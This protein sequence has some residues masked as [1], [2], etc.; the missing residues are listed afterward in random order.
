[1][2]I[3][4]L[5][6]EIFIIVFTVSIVLL[7]IYFLRKPEESNIGKCK[8]TECGCEFEYNKKDTVKYKYEGK[9]YNQTQ[10]PG[11]KNYIEV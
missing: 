5:I 6:L 8:C 7:G 11:C 4:T 2:Q 3:I 9:I 1:M 10:C